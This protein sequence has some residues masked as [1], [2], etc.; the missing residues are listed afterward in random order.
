MTGSST[1][2]A[3]C[4]AAERLSAMAGMSICT[5]WL[6]TGSTID[7]VGVEAGSA[8]ILVSN[9]RVSPYDVIVHSVSWSL[10]RLSCWLGDGFLVTDEA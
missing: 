9:S 10:R 5:G 7:V 3:G 8:L 2:L 1:A 6:E 4:L